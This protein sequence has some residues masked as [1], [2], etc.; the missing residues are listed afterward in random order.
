MA[1]ITITGLKRPRVNLPHIDERDANKTR[2]DVDENEDTE[3]L[4]YESS[5]P[6]A[7]SK[8]DASQLP[9]ELAKLVGHATP[10]PARASRLVLTYWSILRAMK[11]Q[12]SWSHSMKLSSSR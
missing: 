7:W 10:G 8:L 9:Q 6:P 1:K 5:L 2:T 12:P 3:T 4:I 11:H